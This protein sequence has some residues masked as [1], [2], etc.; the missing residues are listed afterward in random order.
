MENQR[1]Y[2]EFEEIFDAPLGISPEEQ[3]AVRAEIQGIVARCQQVP[4]TAHEEAAWRPKKRGALFLVLVN[5]VTLSLLG[6]GLFLFFAPPQGQ[7]ENTP[8]ESMGLALKA[9]RG[10][11]LDSIGANDQK[12]AE[13]SAEIAA[14]DGELRNL[15]QSIDRNAREKEA[16]L[17]GA[18][19]REA[20]AEQIKLIQSDL[21]GDRIMQEMRLFEERNRARLTEEL[22]AYREQLD[23]EALGAEIALRQR[24]ET[25]VQRRAALYGEGAR[26]RENALIKEENLRME[27]TPRAENGEP[28]HP[29]TTE[30]MAITNEWERARRLED[31][32]T[33]FFTLAAEQIKAGGMGEAANTLLS[34][35]AFINTPLFQYSRYLRRTFYLAALDGLAALVDDRLREAPEAPESPEKPV[36]PNTGDE[37]IHRQ[38]A[39]V[40]AEMKARYAELERAAAEKDA[41][42]AA[43]L[44][45]RSRQDTGPGETPEQEL[46]QTI[47][48]LKARNANLQQDLNAR[49]AA[50]KTL[51]AQSASPQQA[52]NARDLNALRSQNAGLQQTINTRDAAINTLRA[53]N[54]ALQQTINAHENRIKELRS[55]TETLQQSIVN[56]ESA[57]SSLRSQNGILQQSLNARD[58][59]IAELRSQSA[60]SQQTVSS[61]DSAINTLRAQNTGLQ[62]A[63]NAHENTIKDLRAQGERLQQLV[64]NRESALNTLRS[65]NA[66]LQ[67]SLNARDAAI[68]EL[69]NRGAD[70]QQSLSSRDSAINALRSQN[71]GLSQRITALEAD[72]S[73]LR[74]QTGNLQQIIAGQDNTISDLRTQNSRLNQTLSGKDTTINDLRTQNAGLNQTLAGKDTTINDLRTQNTGLNQTVEQLRQ[75]NEALRRIRGN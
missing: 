61:R 30:I 36:S 43:A 4:A 31:E 27:L 59:A 68:A 22:A 2:D 26:I 28:E 25:G 11:T 19:N 37:A 54:A 41:A 24:R 12:I 34:A 55:Q 64:T 6:G 67:Q 35:R 13:V 50:L 32:V 46:R 45:A 71:A 7:E 72:N 15:R 63:V 29:A 49:D 74:T 17:R 58:A 66:D 60:N 57:L 21:S 5:C 62:Q 9:L 39:G 65:E 14:I 42:L 44:E 33:G 53:Q 40:M 51:R 70:S 8:G 1:V 18:A 47:D 3:D 73:D 20:E 69:R 38:Y 48:T 23:I 75:T 56:R 16:D 10:E 52:G